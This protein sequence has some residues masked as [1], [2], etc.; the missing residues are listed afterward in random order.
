MSYEISFSETATPSKLSIKPDVFNWSERW[1]KDPP[2]LSLCWWNG[3]EISLPLPAWWFVILLCPMSLTCS[4]I[5]RNCWCDLSAWFV[6]RLRLY[7]DPSSV[8][9]HTGA[10]QMSSLQHRARKT[11]QRQ[12]LNEDRWLERSV[13]VH[14]LE[15]AR[16]LARFLD[17]VCTAV[18]F[19]GAQSF[20]LSA[21]RSGL[22]HRVSL[23]YTPQNRFCLGQQNGII[24]HYE[25]LHT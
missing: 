12:Q 2:P 15:M 14:V 5:I 18:Y 3:R 6:A 4:F 25:A 17:Y 23:W 1:D 9:L 13:L 24:V 20:S 21:S 10:L 22:K 11:G 8:H 19:G 7:A 16:Q